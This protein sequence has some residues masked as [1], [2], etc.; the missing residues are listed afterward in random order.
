MSEPGSAE[1]TQPTGNA[2]NT[3]LALAY[4]QRR[5]EEED[6]ETKLRDWHSGERSL[7]S[8]WPRYRTT[9]GE[10]PLQLSQANQQWL[11]ASCEANQEFLGWL[12]EQVENGNDA[13]I[14]QLAQQQRDWAETA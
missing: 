11:A 12:R 1:G 10:T 4:I 6:P 14:G 13:W 3:E 5:L 8:V 9:A 2:E 7:P